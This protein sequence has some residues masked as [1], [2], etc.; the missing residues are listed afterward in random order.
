MGKLGVGVGEEFP[1]DEGAQAGSEPGGCCGGGDRNEAFHQWREQKRQWRHQMRAQWR[2]RRQAMRG[3][4]RDEFGAND[5]VRSEHFHGHAQHL[6]FAA[7]V[8]IG[9]AALF[10]HR[11]HDH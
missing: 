9:L 4:F 3:R 7:L 6:A 8:V 11:R 5:D 1:V 10:G 2:A